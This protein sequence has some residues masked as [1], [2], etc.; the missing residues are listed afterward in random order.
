MSHGLVQYQWSLLREREINT[1]PTWKIPQNGGKGWEL[2]IVC[3]RACLS[4]W[5]LSIR[6]NTSL[7]F[8]N[9]HQHFLP[10]T[11]K[12]IHHWRSKVGKGCAY[13]LLRKPKLKMRKTIVMMIPQVARTPSVTVT[14]MC[15]VTIS[16]F[17]TPSYG[18]P[19][20]DRQERTSQYVI[21]ASFQAIQTGLRM[22]PKYVNDM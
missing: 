11:A 7:K 4:T 10:C 12:D 15:T 17:G 22:R 9:K 19:S 21:I 6:T 5:M 3:V 13:F 14:A 1:M 16:S 18:I 8:V 2:K 20:T